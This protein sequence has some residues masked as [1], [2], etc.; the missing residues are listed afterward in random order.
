MRA[1]R[2]ITVASLLAGLALAQAPSPAMCQ[3]ALGLPSVLCAMPCCKAHPAVPAKCPLVR[4][5]Q[6]H[7]A[8]N[9]SSRVFKLGLELAAAW[10]SVISASPVFKVTTLKSVVVSCTSLLIG[11]RPTGRAPP[12]DYILFSA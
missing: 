6:N 10:D 2:S 3:M 5:A 8:I 1:F 7:D 4:P 9:P 12:L 11:P